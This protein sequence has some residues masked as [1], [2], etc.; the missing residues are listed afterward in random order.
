MLKVSM[1]FRLGEVFFSDRIEDTS[2]RYFT[3]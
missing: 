2:K 3:V 1:E